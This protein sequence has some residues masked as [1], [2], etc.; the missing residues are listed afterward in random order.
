MAANDR[1]EMESEFSDASFSPTAPPRNPHYPSLRTSSPPR[2]DAVLA[3]DPQAR[4]MA[5]D[6]RR[7][8]LTE[9]LSRAGSL[10][11]KPLSMF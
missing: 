1:G 11:A 4:Q 3:Q 9:S 10:L 5:A 6:V 2:Y 8:G 7:R